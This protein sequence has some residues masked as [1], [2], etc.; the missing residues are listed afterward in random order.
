VPDWNRGIVVGKERY[1]LDTQGIVVRS[2]AG[3]KR[4][5]PIH[6][7]ERL[8]VLLNMCRWYCL[9]IQR[10]GCEADYLNL[11]IYSAEVNSERSY[12]F[13]SQCTFVL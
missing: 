3:A 11:R 5:Y 2:P 10:P 6:H 7:P 4:I 13:S 8:I 12:T 1:G 9:R